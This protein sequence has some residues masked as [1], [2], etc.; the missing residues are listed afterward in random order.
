MSWR[1]LGLSTVGKQTLYVN[2]KRNS[3]YAT[4]SYHPVI[5]KLI[6]NLQGHDYCLIGVFRNLKAHFAS[7]ISPMNDFVWEVTFHIQHSTDFITIS[8]TTIEVSQIF[9]CASYHIVFSTL[10]VVLIFPGNFLSGTG[11]DIT[12]YYIITCVSVKSKLY[13]SLSFFSGIWHEL[14]WFFR[15]LR[16]AVQIPPS[17]SQNAVH[18]Y[19][20]L[21]SSDFRWSCTQPRQ[22]KTEVTI[23]PIFS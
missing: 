16:L 15:R 18:M 20:P 7:L 3:D 8:N 9:H 13:N 21:H 11:F 19:T 1:E 22:I 4:T 23:L 6:F 10:S 17:A 5:L 12:E 2:R 14:I